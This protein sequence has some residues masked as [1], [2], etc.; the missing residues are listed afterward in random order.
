MQGK[1]TELDK[2]IIEAIKDPLTHLVRN[3]VD[4]ALNFRSGASKPERREPDG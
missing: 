2:T 3:S 1:E 4:T